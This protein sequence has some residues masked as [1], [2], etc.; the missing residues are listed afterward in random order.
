MLIQILNS[1]VK[2]R[3]IDLSLEN[4]GE[5]KALADIRMKGFAKLTSIDEALDEFFK[6]INVKKLEPEEISTVAALRRVLATDILCPRDVPP[7]D[8][9][10]VDGY[11]I[12]AEDVFGAS[13]TNPIVLYVKGTSRTGK[14]PEQ[15][16]RCGEAMLIAT[17]APLPEGANAVVMIEFTEATGFNKVEVYRPI[18]PG[19]NVSAQGEDVKKG[20]LILKAGSFLK[21]PDIG[22]LAALGLAKVQVTRKPLVAILSTGNEL[23]ELGSEMP[24][25]RIVDS[26]R[27]VLHAMVEMSGAEPLDLGVVPDERNKICEKMKMGLNSSDLILA[28]G[29]TSVG[30]HDILPD[31]VN[32]LGSPGV[33]IHG[34]AM[35]PGRPVAL[36]LVDGKPIV[37]LPGFPVAAMVAYD[38]FVEPII[39]RMLG[40]SARFYEQPS[41][42]A[43]ALRRVPSSSGNRSFVRVLV[44]RKGGQIVFEPLRASGSGV[45]SSMVKANGMLII[46]EYK[47]GVEEGEEAK[48]IL[49]R[50]VEEEKE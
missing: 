39:L 2:I 9:S 6:K 1:L 11:A 33:L 16:L 31:V 25:G 15:S 10:A 8:R 46:P 17:G 21:P 41:V 22:I 43:I 4:I 7:F 24:H 35:R 49:L 44:M 40:A 14:V 38:V 29:G 37:L 13:D 27:P 48:V 20:Q 34:V 42:M 28:S 30:E 12:R 19:E 50:P 26:N 32:S 23:V 5:E 3:L 18:S 45:I 36:C 47:E